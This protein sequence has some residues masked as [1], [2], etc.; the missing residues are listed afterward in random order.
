MIMLS[1]IHVNVLYF[2]G[3]KDATGVRMESME[4]PKNTSVKELLS[5]LSMTHPKIRDMLNIIQIS[6]NY[7]VVDKGTILN[8]GDEVA[9]LPPISGG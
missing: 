6:V 9:I 7:M 4:L 8:E 3:A 1:T 5:Y 2:A